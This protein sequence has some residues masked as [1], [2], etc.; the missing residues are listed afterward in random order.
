MDKN[1]NHWEIVEGGKIVTSDTPQGMW[2]LAVMYFQWCDENPLILKRTIMSGKD[3]GMKVEEEKPRPYTIKGLCLHC[4]FLEEHLR[5]VR[6]TKDQGSD[7]YL[8]VTKILYQIHTQNAEYA[9]IGEFSP[10][11]TAKMLNMESEEVPTGSI[12]VEVVGG[13]PTLS[14]SEIQVIENLEKDGNLFVSEGG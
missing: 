10:V 5:D 4:G 14:S 2:Q 3:A 8:V 1:R 11:F 12:K 7:Y 6:A 13:L 9:M